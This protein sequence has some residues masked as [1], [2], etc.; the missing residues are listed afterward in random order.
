MNKKEGWLIKDLSTGKIDFGTR[1]PVTAR[2]AK[3][4]P[5][6]EGFEWVKVL[7]IIVEVKG[8]LK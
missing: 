7:T 3:A 1:R 8:E 5:L 2:Y 4:T 6:V